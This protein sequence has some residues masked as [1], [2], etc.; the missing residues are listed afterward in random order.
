MAVVRGATLARL[1]QVLEL[2]VTSAEGLDSTEQIDETELLDLIAEIF[3]P[4][5]S[6]EAKVGGITEA[7]RLL[8]DQ[9]L[10][11]PTVGVDSGGVEMSQAVATSYLRALA[12]HW[13]SLAWAAAQADAVA[14]VLEL[15]GGQDA[16]LSRV[17]GSSSVTSVASTTSSLP[18][19]LLR[20]DAIDV[21]DVL[22]LVDIESGDLCDVDDNRSAKVA[23]VATADS[24]GCYM[25]RGD[26]FS[27]KA[28]LSVDGVRERLA[29][30]AAAVLTG[31]AHAALAQATSYAK[32]RSQF[33]APIWDLDPVRI[34]L[35]KHDELVAMAAARLAH[36]SSS[37]E[38]SAAPGVLD[39]AGNVSIEAITAAMETLGGYG[40]LHEYGLEWR[41]R[42]SMTLVAASRWLAR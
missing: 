14:R 12:M 41:L 2:T 22:L 18:H 23:T 10:W 42:N 17:A 3:K 13:P 21:P 36:V 24:L 33:G 1:V 31:S 34:R 7:A 11:C 35:Q 30:A 39:A 9:G 38:W 20:V 27:S 19:G 29:L 15:D 4:F 6:A 32:W 16:V 8:A 26:A 37:G 5:E 25:L 28:R 40:Y